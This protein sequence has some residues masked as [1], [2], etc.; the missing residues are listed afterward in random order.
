MVHPAD[1]DVRP[2]RSVAIRSRGGPL[3]DIDETH[4]AFDPLHFVLLFPYG[5]DGWTPGLHQRPYG[6]AVPPVTEDMDVA[7]CWNP[8]S[9]RFQTRRQSDSETRVFEERNPAPRQTAD[10]KSQ[11][12]CRQRKWP[13]RTTQQEVQDPPE[14]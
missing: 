14:N 11:I 4:R 7:D 3:H 13:A 8:Q 12:S 5:C 9:G 2:K 6:G 10:R 1:A